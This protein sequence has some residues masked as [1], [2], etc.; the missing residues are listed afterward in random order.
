MEQ[1]FRVAQYF[2][3][4]AEEEDYFLK[5]VEYERC[6]DAGYK[7]RLKSQLV[8]LKNQLENFNK[9][10]N[11][12]SLDAFGNS[13][14][15]LS[16]YSS[17]HWTAIHMAVGIPEYQTPRAIGI[18][19]GLS[20][21]FVLR[22]LHRLK[23]FGLVKEQRGKWVMAVS[24]VHLSGMSPLHSVQHRNWQARA[25]LKAQDPTHDGLNYSVVASISRRDF[26]KVKDLLLAS[27]DDCHRIVR[28]SP[29]EELVCLCLDFFRV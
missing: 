6:G 17:W 10:L 5:L 25:S 22:S 24:D 1:A 16:Y 15:A 13:D 4:K 11:V 23:E 18:R 20:E 19:L 12:P 9:R 7:Q 8:A 28:P 21:E 2:R 3:L 26:E 29:S 14:V 27:I